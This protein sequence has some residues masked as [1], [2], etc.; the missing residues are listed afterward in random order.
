ML[1]T[2]C[3]P[4]KGVSR[5]VIVDV[6]RGE[7]FF[8][9]NYLYEILT[10]SKQ[11]KWSTIIAEYDED[12]QSMLDKY[13]KFLEV[14]ELCF[15]TDQPDC[16]PNLNLEWDSPSVIT[17]AII[18]VNTTSEH[19]WEQILKQLSE[20]GCRDIQVRFFDFV[21]IAMI[22]K[23]LA[24]LN[25]SFI[26]SI[27]LIVKYQPVFT[28]KYLKTLIDNNVRIKNFILH[29]APKQDLFQYDHSRGMGNI[30]F[31]KSPVDSNRHCGIINE[32]YFIIDQPRTFAEFKHYN[33]CLNRKIGIDEQGNIK[34]CPSMPIVYGNIKVDKIES[35]I[36]E[37]F[38]NVWFI[39]KDQIETCKICEFR[40]VCSDC[41]AFKENENDILSKPQKCGYDPYTMEW[42]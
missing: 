17:N 20:L 27:E 18:D 1:F 36:T 6:Q 12:S 31:L 19:N 25:N 41:R 37:N 24:L 2:N 33:S 40:Y 23:I 32:H 39:N 29:S 22:E 4:V 7:M 30:V 3:I 11:N 5:S 21:E 13:L 28:R 26:K 16:F 34:N 14:N 42:K 10:S 35:V 15:W 38:K 9:D 8:I